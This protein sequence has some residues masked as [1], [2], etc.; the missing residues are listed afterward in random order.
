MRLITKLPATLTLL[1][2]LLSPFAALAATSGSHYPAGGEG[3]LAATMPPEGFHYRVYNT[4]Y[5]PTQKNDNSGDD[6]GVDFDLDVFSTAHRFINSTG[7]KIMG[8]DLV[9][10]VVIPMVSTDISISDYGI[11]DSKS[12]SLGDVTIEPLALTW[13]N[14]RWD[15]SFALSLIV[16]TGEY[17]ADKAASPGLGYWSGMLSLGGT[18]FFD[19]E[20]SLSFS[21][22][23]R[24]LV[25]T[26]QDDTGVTPGSEFVIEYG[27]G[28]EFMINEKMLVRPGISGWAYWQIEDDSDDGPGTVASERKKSAAL[29]FEIN[30]MH[31]PT[32]FQA[33]LRVAREFE[34]KNTTEGSQIVLTLT[35]SF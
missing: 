27:L 12:L 32:K 35:K 13:R 20:H 14:K 29:G 5:N 15:A 3:V 4:W 19:D 33:N 30:A 2:L 28:K 25:H 31:L 22:L 1:I 23:S 7:I 10:N 8:A 17:D 6:S 34:A 9:C 21:A 26:E 24:T 16:P 11:N 18:Y